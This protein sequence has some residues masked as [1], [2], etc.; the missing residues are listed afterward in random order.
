MHFLIVSFSQKFVEDL[1]IYKVQVVK[2]TQKKIELGGSPQ[3]TSASSSPDNYPIYPSL[4]QLF[5]TAER[6]LSNRKD[7]YSALA[8]ERLGGFMTTYFITLPDPGQPY[9]FFYTF[10]YG[11]DDMLKNKQRKGSLKV[12]RRSPP[13]S[14]LSHPRVSDGVCW[15]PLR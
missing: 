14:S 12:K 5:T 6:V 2:Q 10:P 8:V 1:S 4:R 11:Y 3:S 13:H 15:M 7:L 9:P